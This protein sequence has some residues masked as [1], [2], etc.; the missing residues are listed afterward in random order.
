MTLLN[1]DASIPS[2]MWPVVRLLEPPTMAL[3]WDSLRSLL[4]PTSI[5]ENRVDD[6]Q[7]TVDHAITSLRDLGV[8]ALEGD[9]VTLAP[10][11]AEPPLTNT[12]AFLNLLRTAC[13]DPRRNQD[14]SGPSDHGPLDLVR[15]LVWFLSL[16]PLEEPVGWTKVQVLQDSVDWAAGRPFENGTRWTRF[17]YWATS[18]GFARRHPFL[19]DARKHALVPDCTV[20]VRE[21][22]ARLWRRGAR[23]TATEFVECLCN[24]L[25]VFP[26]GGYAKDLGMAGDATSQLSPSLSNALLSG[27]EEG[28]ITLSRQADSQYDIV[29]T[30]RDRIDGIRRVTEI[31]IHGGHSG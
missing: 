6:P 3:P 22:I 26:E 19:D 18:L 31:E 21:T 25:P 8:L 9:H 23:L 12:T 16:D 28:W 7:K 29:L 24:A 10:H 30:D 4:S 27:N 13:L 15:G 2:F 20:A 11:A 14:V 17:F 5:F 1:V